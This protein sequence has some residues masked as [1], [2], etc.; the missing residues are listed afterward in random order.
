MSGMAKNIDR[1]NARGIEILFIAA[2]VLT[3]ASTSLGAG[4]EIPPGRYLIGSVSVAGNLNVTEAAILARVRSRAGDSF[5]PAV[6]AEDA[7]RIAGVQ[8]VRYAYYNAQVQD[9]AVNLTYVVVE[10]LVVRGIA[11]DGNRRYRDATLLRRLPFKKGDHLDR[12]L[13]EAG[14]R[15]IREFYIEKGHAFVEISVDAAELETGR[16]VYQIEEGPRVKVARV[17]FVGN[18]RL[19]TR[20]LRDVVEISAR[21]LMVFQGHYR[22][23]EV[24]QDV[25]RLQEAYLKR[26]FLDVRI[27]SSTEFSP[28]NDRVAVTFNIHEGPVYRV[29]HLNIAG[30]EFF[31]HEELTE[32]L[33]LRPGEVFT[34]QKADFDRQKMIDRFLAAGFIDMRLDQT[35]SFAGEAEVDVQV[36]VTQGERYRIGRI[37]IIG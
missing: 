26:G 1:W 9:G 16:V 23:Q 14:A 7:R 37:N 22:Q 21:R 4:E 8:G 15:D 13:V 20:N 27:T 10:R 6:A 18:Q 31:T 35:R 11:I 30:N 24:E 19:R 29:R 5:D 25:A 32:D 2:A 12:L 28:N 3:L 36:N 34:P 17:S 33:R